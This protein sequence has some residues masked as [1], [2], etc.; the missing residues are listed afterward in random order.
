M[1]SPDEPMRLELAAAYLALGK[2]SDDDAIAAASSALDEG[3]YSESLGLVFSEKPRFSEAL[4]LFAAALYELGIP[5]PP[6]DEASVT[7]AREYAWSIAEG[8]V[9]PYEGARR[10]WWQLANEPGADPS[11]GIFVGLASE[12][13]DSPEHRP[14]CEAAIIEEARELVN[15]EANK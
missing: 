3:L 5:A 15:G 11:L 9:S 1:P 13:E 7:I 4:R 6:R 10:I 12:W 8:R 2:L 14:A